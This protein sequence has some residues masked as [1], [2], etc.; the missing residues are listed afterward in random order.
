MSGCAWCVLH[1]FA[2]LL[3]FPALFV[4]IPLHVICAT[5]AGGQRIAQ[6]ERTRAARKSAFAYDPEESK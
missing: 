6:E 4:T 2:F 3:F 5:I 1:L